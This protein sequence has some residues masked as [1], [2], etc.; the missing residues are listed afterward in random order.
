M[1][2]IRLCKKFVSLL[3]LSFLQVLEDWCQ[4]VM[5]G[6]IR[7]LAQV[8]VYDF[9]CSSFVY[10]GSGGSL[11]DG[12][13]IGQAQSALGEAMLAVLDHLLILHVL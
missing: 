1:P 12:P 5:R 13:K 7:G 8:Q 9:C 4:D 11:I 2:R 10:E 3:F 6:Q